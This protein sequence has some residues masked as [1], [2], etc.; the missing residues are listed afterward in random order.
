M[1]IA[2]A[3]KLTGAHPIPSSG[4]GAYS[5]ALRDAAVLTTSYVA[6]SHMPCEEAPSVGFW[7]AYSATIDYTSIEVIVQASLD[8]TAYFDVAASASYTIANLGSGAGAAGG[9][10]VKGDMSPGARFAR[11]LVK[12]TGG[13]AVGT[14]TIT[15]VAGGPA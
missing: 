9:V 6:S 12:R 11:I 14:V 3:T 15:G 13:T 10:L 8:G 5:W 2:T 4:K 7:V 1:A